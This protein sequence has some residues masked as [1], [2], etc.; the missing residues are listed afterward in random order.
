MKKESKLVVEFMG[1]DSE[2]LIHGNYK[3]RI[4]YPVK[5]NKEGI[6]VEYDSNRPNLVTEF[7]FPSELK[8]NSSLFWL[9][10]VIKKVEYLGGKI[11][12]GSIAYRFRKCV[13]FIKEYNNEH[14]R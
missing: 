4:V 1:Y 11:E 14:G 10:D 3:G 9:N 13:E 6:H 7:Y 12:G 5:R 2:E 8:Y